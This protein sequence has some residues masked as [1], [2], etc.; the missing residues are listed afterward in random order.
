MLHQTGRCRLVLLNR[1]DSRPYYAGCDTIREVVTRAN[2]P[3]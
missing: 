1:F 3:V 2:F